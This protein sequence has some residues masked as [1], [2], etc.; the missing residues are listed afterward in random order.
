MSTLK[1]HSIQELNVDWKIPGDKSISHRA[2]LLGSLTHG[3]CHV[4]NFLPSQDC[5]ASLRAMQALGASIETIDE[6]SFLLTGRGY[7]LESP[8]EPID[9][10]NS[11]TTMRLLSGILAGQQFTSRLTG[12]HSLHRRPMRRIAN[13]L[14]KMGATV[15]CRGKDGRPP[16]DIEGADLSAIDYRTPIPSAQLKSCLLLAGL[17]AEGKTTVRE[18]APSRDH[19]ERMLKHLSAAIATEKNCVHV[20]GRQPLQ[21]EPIAIPGDFSSAAFWIVAGAALPGSRVRLQHVGLNPTRTALLNVLSRMGAVIHEQME[22]IHLEPTGNVMVEGSGNLIGTEIGGNEIPNLIDEI[23]ILTVAAALA[24]GTTI[25]RDAEELRVKESDRLA[26]LA[27]N[28]KAFGVEVKENP[29]GLEIH[30]GR[31]LVGADVDSLGDHR[32]AMSAAIMGLFASGVTRV[33]NTACIATS[34][35]GFTRHLAEVQQQQPRIKVSFPVR[36]WIRSLKKSSANGSPASTPEKKRPMNTAIAI[37]GTAASGKS[38]VAKALAKELKFVYVDTGAMYRTY[39]WLANEKNM[40]PADRSA[41]KELIE[42]TKLDISVRKGELI[43]TVNGEDPEPHIRSEAVNQSVSKIASVPELREH[44][45]NAQRA[46]RLDHPVVMEGRDIGTVVF[47][48]TPHKYYIDADNEVR[49]KRRQDQGQIDFLSDR[50]ELDKKRAAAPLVPAADARVIDST[51][52]TPD[53]IVSE[54]LK[55]LKET[56]LSTTSL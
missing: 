50:D 14:K 10:G 56:G 41:V 7:R 38:T 49:A 35:P 52:K 30:G 1:V 3:T 23:P 33:R 44:L 29:D 48:D 45:V 34:Y 16:L 4:T 22:T 25:I 19:T 27:T 37:D 20:Y 26:A 47:T 53:E 21:A 11:G 40:D 6:T 36:K 55:E 46:I 5:L 31:P 12:D 54:I 18:S 24:E 9:C 13:P 28:L 39:A 15:H 32:I 51:H 42:E 43:L 2:A 8:L 17:Q